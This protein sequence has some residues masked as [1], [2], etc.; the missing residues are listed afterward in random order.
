MFVFPRRLN[1]LSR[2]HR[3]VDLALL[4]K[5]GVGWEIAALEM[6]D[7]VFSNV[8]HYRDPVLKFCRRHTAGDLSQ[9]TFCIQ[10]FFPGGSAMAAWKWTLHCYNFVVLDGGRLTN[11]L[12]D[13]LASVAPKKNNESKQ[14]DQIL[15]SSTTFAPLV[16]KARW[17]VRG[18]GDW[19]EI[20]KLKAKYSSLDLPLPACA[21]ALSFV[22]TL[23]AGV[24]LQGSDGRC[25]STQLPICSEAFFSLNECS[26][27]QNECSWSLQTNFYR[28]FGRF[29]SALVAGLFFFVFQFRSY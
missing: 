17:S 4:F 21:A 2:F 23:F 19:K 9:S 8:H 18:K 28:T 29:V 13:L 15:S 10:N 14:A 5:K 27:S 11:F 1:L 3:W 25:V 16:A 26:F 12:R 24:D 20:A 7:N 22:A 6:A